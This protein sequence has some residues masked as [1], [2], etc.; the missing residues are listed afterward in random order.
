MRNG[1][2]GIT[3]E[4]HDSG[5]KSF[6]KNL[7]VNE[8]VELLNMLHEENTEFRTALKELREIGDYQAHRINELDKENMKLE[9]QL[10]NLRRL[11]NIEYMEGS[12]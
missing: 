11:V 8:T 5:D 6:P 2:I 9:E 12:E 7:T 3:D 4:L 1:Q 10:R